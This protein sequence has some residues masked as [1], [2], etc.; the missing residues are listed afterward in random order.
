MYRFFALISFLFIST[1]AFPQA[2]SITPY[3]RIGIGELYKDRVGKS[4]GMGGIALGLRSNEHIN[5]A[6]PAS[7]TS[8]D[9]ATF[10]FQVGI[11]EKLSFMQTSTSK[12]SLDNFNLEYMTMQFPITKWWAG[13]IGL[14]PFSSVGYNIDFTEDYVDD[15]STLQVSHKYFGDGGI[16]R[17]YIGQSFELFKRLS[18]G[19][20]VSY[21]FGANVISSKLVF[22]DD[23]LAFSYLSEDTVSFSDLYFDFGAQYSQPLFK[24]KYNLVL[25]G[26]FTNKQQISAQKSKFVSIFNSST[27]NPVLDSLVSDGKVETPMSYGF[28]LSFTDNEHFTVGADFYTQK[29]KNTLSFGVSDSLAD[30]KLICLGGEYVPSKDPISKYWK[31]IRYRVG[32]YYSNTYMAMNGTQINDLGVSVGFGFPLRKSKTMFNVSFEMGQKGTIENSL[33]KENYYG[34]SL[35]LSLIDNWFYKQKID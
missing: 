16:N 29:W 5:F 19:A 35:N 31:R 3:S 6:N 13:S 15:G 4:R 14:V 28:G 20:N 22:D 27:S 18:I 32:G 9:S 21:L 11:A 1:L 10:I 25:G 2:G 7:Y 26:V 17:F 24:N 8:V 33:I 34:I 30:S 12:T 23:A